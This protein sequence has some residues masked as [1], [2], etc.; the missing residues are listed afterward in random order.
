MNK[1]LSCMVEEEKINGSDATT[2]LM[3]YDRKGKGIGTQSYKSFYC[4]GILEEIEMSG[5]ARRVALLSDRERIFE[6]LRC[7]DKSC[8][9]IVE[10]KRHVQLERVNRQVEAPDWLK[11]NT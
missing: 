9:Q 2:S 7:F 8:R 11:Q 5:K 3:S 6:S 10:G 4:R 1:V